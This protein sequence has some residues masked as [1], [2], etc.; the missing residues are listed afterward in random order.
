MDKEGNGTKKD[1][2]RKRLFEYRTSGSRPRFPS[3]LSDPPQIGIWED[4]SLAMS[5]LYGY[6]AVWARHGMEKDGIKPSRGQGYH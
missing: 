1:M 6:G 2:G 5:Q 4:T 3:S